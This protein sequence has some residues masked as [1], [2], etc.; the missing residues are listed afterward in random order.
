MPSDPRSVRL[1]RW[2]STRPAALAVGAVA[3]ALWLE[4]AVLRSAGTPWITVALLP[5]V[6]LAA[7]FGG[8]GAGVCA[9][10]LGALALDLVVVTPRVMFWHSAPEAV[11][12]AVFTMG[13]LIVTIAAGRLNRRV[14]AQGAERDEAEHAAWQAR[15]LAELA[16][17][18]S[19][20]R[21][22]G[23]AMDACIQEGV[24]GV[25][26]DAA[27]FLLVDHAAGRATVARAIE[28]DAPADEPGV[29]LEGRNPVADAVRQR[30]A[31]VIESRGGRRA[32][33][34]D[35]AAIC[36]RD[37]EASIAVPI[38][39][40]GQVVAALL[41][42]FRTP[43]TF[44]S[45]DREFLHAL[46]VRTGHALDRT[47]QHEA[48]E[49]ARIEAEGL[50]ARADQELAERLKIEQALRTS[51]TRYRALAART[52]RLH[53]LTAALSEAITLGAV[54]RAVVRHGKIVAG[55]TA[56]EV[57]LLMED[58]EA[59]QTIYAEGPD[60][61][62]A[63]L[64][65]VA[66][67]PGLCAT[68]AIRTGEPVFVGSF[69]EWQER[70]ARS[71]S[72]DADGGYTSSATLPVLVEGAPIGVLA[73]HFTAP[74]N[75]DE[76]YRAL[77]VSA[78]Q[79][80]AQALDRGRL[81]EAAEQARKEA[82]E[83]NRLKDE[84]LSI[85]SHELRTPLNSILGWASM[86]RR[87]GLDGAVI[88][89]GLQTIHDNA[90]RQA[91]LIDEL[92]DFS[93]IVAGRTTLDVQPL[94][95]RPVLERVV[96]SMMPV[97]A[98]QGVELHLG[99]VP[100]VAIAGDMRR[101]EQVFFNLLSN[102]VKFT[103]AGGRV[104]LRADASAATVRIRVSDTG[105]GID[106]EFLPYV[107]D[108]FRQGDSTAT[109]SHGG[110][111]LGLSIAKYMVEAHKGTIAAESGGK[112]QGA[113]FE[114]TLPLLP[115]Q[116]EP[117]GIDQE[118]PALHVRPEPSNP[119]HLAGVRVLVVDDEADAR[120]MMAQ[121]LEMCGA[122][123]SL[124]E[125]ASEALEILARD[126]VDVL[127]AD[128]AMPGEDGYSLIRSV[129]TSCLPAASVPAAAVT[130]HARDDERRRALEAGFQLH[131]V[132]PL[133]PDQ[134]AQAVRRLAGPPPS[135]GAAPPVPGQEV[136]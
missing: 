126:S 132:K 131:L 54:G 127:L 19:T 9:T 112:G 124:A 55:A 29:P 104:D 59:L 47:W 84:F 117:A 95:L 23:A 83:A 100:S 35:A 86:L 10:L 14:L 120:M 80:C 71:A 64:T 7:L 98:A 41:L 63:P 30:L 122:E 12:L 1:V 111:G 82:E 91:R 90:T 16:T 128:I 101:L 119:P 26:A 51:E 28:C 75:F 58:G 48:A 97:A 72:I 114:V 13:G 38:G 44:T 123:V 11:G 22:P 89:R 133:E 130:A 78:A 45:E 66:V 60:G 17:A 18:M 70:Y 79:H 103:P 42:E 34:G 32:E 68:D 50:R 74:V 46:A 62:A 6:V 36:L 113:T 2:I 33:Y 57:M 24:H 88:T 53:D 65:R 27:A 77:L 39:A 56:G 108:R 118:A 129:R 49:R 25:R 136:A 125:G 134:L 106:T 107:F 76:D 135:G 52:R 31:V 93:R 61:E 110:I 5:A 109:R 116:A 85:V 73:F 8:P 4:L 115:G 3:A 21:A 94:A 102:A 105:A 87:S 43:R 15:R 81:Y 69:G 40:G 99:A 67:E 121:A 37:P 96:E 92:L 20:V